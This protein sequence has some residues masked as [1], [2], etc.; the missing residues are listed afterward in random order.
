MASSKECTFYIA[1]VPGEVKTTRGIWGIT[2][3]AWDNRLGPSPNH[4][5]QDARGKVGGRYG[6]G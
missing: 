3:Q 1:I 6:L 4:Q 5:R 2:G